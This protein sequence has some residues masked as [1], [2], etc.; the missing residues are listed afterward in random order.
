MKREYKLNIADFPI[1][2]VEINDPPYYSEDLYEL[3]G[4]KGYVVTFTFRQDTDTAKRYGE[5][6]TGSIFYPKGTKQ[7]IEKCIKENALYADT[8]VR[9]SIILPRLNQ[10]DI[11]ELKYK[12]FPIDHIQYLHFVPFEREPETE[13]GLKVVPNIIKIPVSTANFNVDHEIF[14]Q[15][16]IFRKLKQGTELIPEEKAYLVGSILAMDQN[17][18]DPD[19][20]TV[21]GYTTDSAGNDRRIWYHYYQTKRRR[22]IL[23]E[24]EVQKL[25]KVED[26]DIS[27]K[28]TLLARELATGH[29]PG[30]ALT[31]KMSKF[32]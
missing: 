23:S 22:R 11:D 29:V 1:F 28:M 27:D 6:I 13:S 18:I 4:S 19:L 3:I 26:E 20:L 24:I 5:S 16:V 7:Q 17:Q 8:N 10:L 14:I 31:L 15:N 9:L 21:L 25:K 30:E 32:R 2:M 12:G